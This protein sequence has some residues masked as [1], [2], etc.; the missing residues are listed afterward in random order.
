MSIEGFFE[1]GIFSWVILPLLIFVSRIFD[2]SLGTIRII[3]V[4]RRNKILAPLLGFF[5]VLIWLV[6]I[7]QIMKNLNNAVCF[8]A[9]AAGFSAGTY[10]GI[11]LEEKLALGTLIVRIILVKDECKL[12]ERL[13]GEGFGVT[14]VDAKGVNGSV[15]LIYTVIKRKDL[16]RVEEII[17]R[18]NSKSF[19]SVEEARTVR[20]GI[21]PSTNVKGALSRKNRKYERHGK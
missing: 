13:S 21:F 5:E 14:S 12:I 17:N 18:C 1:G 16:M 6:A 19:Y 7:S 2:V 10:I 20:E 11:M 4:S 15:K 3:F 9:Y 8:I